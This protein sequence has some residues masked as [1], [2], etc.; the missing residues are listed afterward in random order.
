M[1]KSIQRLKRGKRSRLDYE[2]TYI[3]ISDKWE[4]KARAL[5]ARR[6]KILRQMAAQD[7]E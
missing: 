5:Q 1:K 7:T 4:E 6:W 3:E 2:T